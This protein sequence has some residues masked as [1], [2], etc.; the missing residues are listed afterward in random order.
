MAIL[1]Q[2][3]FSKGQAIRCQ[4]GTAL[5][6]MLGAAIAVHT[7]QTSADLLSNITAGGFIYVATVDVLP[8]LL[9]VRAAI[10]GALP[11]HPLCPFLPSLALTPFRPSL[12]QVRTSIWGTLAQL[13][14]MALGVGMMLVVMAFE[15]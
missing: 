7:G 15:G 6:A 13:S 1:M 14:A 9:L 4:L 3:G 2:A 5:A 8:P 10:G 11:H 12:A